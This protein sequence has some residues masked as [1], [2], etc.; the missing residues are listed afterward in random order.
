[1]HLVQVPRD[2][3]SDQKLRDLE[4][5]K[6]QVAELSD[7][8]RQ[9][10]AG[11]EQQ[12]YTEMASLKASL[13]NLSSKVDSLTAPSAAVEPAAVPAHRVSEVLMPIRVS[14]DD[15]E[16]DTVSL[17]LRISAEE[18][19]LPAAQLVGA[20]PV[21]DVE[22]STIQ[23]NLQQLS[24]R[25]AGLE[26][27]LKQVSSQ[28]AGAEPGS[29]VASRSLA[30]TDSFSFG[31][32]AAGTAETI[33]ST[34]NV[35]AE[36]LNALAKEVRDLEETVETQ[37][38]SIRELQAVASEAAA[39]KTELDAMADNISTQAEAAVAA[40]L[41]AQPRRAPEAGGSPGVPLGARSPQRV[42]T[43]GVPESSPP[44]PATPSRSIAASQGQFLQ[45]LVEVV[46]RQSSR[47]RSQYAEE[48]DLD[49]QLAE[50][51]QGQWQLT[52][53]IVRYCT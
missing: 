48:E 11:F 8:A 39:M 12:V 26:E 20:G 22:L 51:R 45:R 7:S 31:G 18:E 47:M 46:K 2:A 4:S 1:M 13:I 38:A 50:V 35:L 29:T 10:M 6:D 33:Q 36:A 30:T 32:E 42:S 40:A 49:K 25:V 52:Y 21:P 34:N 43:S 28:S 19:D 17:Q 53:S 27:E 41:L 15:L 14:A 16:T 9:A 23:R 3:G 24:E 37:E 5:L 44:R